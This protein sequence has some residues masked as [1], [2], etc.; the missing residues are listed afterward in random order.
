MRVLL[1]DDSPM[2]QKI[3]KIYLEK[4][5]GYTVLSAVNGRE[6]V[7]MAKKEKPD[8]ILLD[9]EMP[10]MSGEE[11]LKE[12][13]LSELTKDIPVIMCT[14]AEEEGLEQRLLSIGAASFIKKPHGFSLLKNIVKDLGAK[15]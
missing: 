15:G 11:A 5:E 8:L 4:G 1:V 12:L 7:D 9:V 3:A 2:Q 6:G 10:E 13:K 14:A